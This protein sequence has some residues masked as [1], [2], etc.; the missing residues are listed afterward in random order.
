MIIYI[1][2]DWHIGV[3][4]HS[5]LFIIN[6]VLTEMIVMKKSALTG[7]KLPV[8]EICSVIVLPK[9]LH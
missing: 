6:L 9:P 7:I 3:L 1:I 4:H 2:F 8:D 5:I